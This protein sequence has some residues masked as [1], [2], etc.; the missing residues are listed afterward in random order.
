MFQLFTMF[1][2]SR[3]IPS[4][5]CSCRVRTRL[6]HQHQR[7][8]CHS[9]ICIPPAFQVCSSSCSCSSCCRT[10]WASCC[11]TSCS[12]CFPSCCR[13]CT[14]HQHRPRR[15][16]TSCRSCICSPLACLVCCSSSSCS[17]SH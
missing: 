5:C 11:L 3:C 2:C 6:Q 13:V 10:S 1:S 14:K 12:S 16:Q 9:C 15:Q 7:T 4:C 17:S 8:S